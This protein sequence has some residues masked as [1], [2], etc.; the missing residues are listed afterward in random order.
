M[1]DTTSL[2]TLMTT[3][4]TVFPEAVLDEDNDKQI[5][6]YTGLYQTGDEDCQ[7]I[8]REAGAK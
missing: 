8:E 5:I 7:L 4:R 3:I 1:I 2:N 6:I